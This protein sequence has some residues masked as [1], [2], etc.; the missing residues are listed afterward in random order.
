[1]RAPVL[2]LAVG[3]DDTSDD[4]AMDST[5]AEPK[6][7]RQLK[8]YAC[9]QGACSG[10]GKIFKTEK[11]ARSHL[12]KVH[13]TRLH[14]KN[15]SKGEKTRIL[16]NTQKEWLR[17]ELMRDNARLFKVRNRRRRAEINSTHVCSLCHRRYG[18]LKS[19]RHHFHLKHT[20]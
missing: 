5:D 18:S 1:M 4:G 14:R 20:I 6:S 10:S 16:N 11:G 19:L 15:L 7:S 9:I 17:Q 3:N 12:W 8:V 2:S 13:L